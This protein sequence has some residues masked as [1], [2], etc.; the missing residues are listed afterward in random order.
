MHGIKWFAQTEESVRGKDK[1]IDFCLPLTMGSSLTM[2]SGFVS[3]NFLMKVLW[4]AQG[5]R[6]TLATLI[7][8]I[9]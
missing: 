6:L 1:D 8:Y 4:N 5:F 7:N 2:S 9:C 3:G